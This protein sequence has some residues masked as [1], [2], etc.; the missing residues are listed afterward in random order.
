[1]FRHQRRSPGGVPENEHRKTGI[2]HEQPADHVEGRD[3]RLGH[4][5]HVGSD[6]QKR[7]A[8]DHPRPEPAERRS[9]RVDGNTD[10]RIEQNVDQSDHGERETDRS[11]GKPDMAR[12]VVREI[13]R[14]WNTKRRG[15]H[16]RARKWRKQARG[17]PLHR[18][19]D[20]LTHRQ[21]S[22]IASLSD[23]LGESSDGFWLRRNRNSRAVLPDQL[24]RHARSLSAPNS[25]SGGS[26]VRLCNASRAP[27]IASDADK[28]MRMSAWRF[29]SS[30]YPHMAKPP[31][32]TQTTGG[33][34]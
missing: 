16:G 31:I 29:S 3:A 34:R 6:H 30:L 27:A 33:T 32:S 25:G 2:K 20:R 12:V 5:D 26:P 8:G 19:L 1:I 10:Q 28:A 23:T 22:R 24:A 14:Q 18:T 7:R 13:D 17:Q 9:R 15:R 11:Q 21:A 4:E